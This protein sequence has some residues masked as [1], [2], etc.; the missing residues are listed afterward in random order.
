LQDAGEI[1]EPIP[2]RW[3]LPR[4]AAS[5]GWPSSPGPFRGPAPACSASNRMPVPLTPRAQ[6]RWAETSESDGRQALRRSG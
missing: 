4:G 1:N 5:A 3:G 6:S 2:C